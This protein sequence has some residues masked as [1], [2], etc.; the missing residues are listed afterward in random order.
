VEL[1]LKLS[2]G[3]ERATAAD[4]VIGVLVG[5]AGV[6]LDEQRALGPV[7]IRGQAGLKSSKSLTAAHTPCA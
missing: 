6:E 2:T 1:L 4:R 5:Q 7:S 3:G